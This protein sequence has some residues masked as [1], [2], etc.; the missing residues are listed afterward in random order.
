MPV[1]FL[2]IGI[3]ILKA[4]IPVGYVAMVLERELGLRAAPFATIFTL[5]IIL[6]T[7]PADLTSDILNT[8]LQK[9]LFST[10]SARVVLTSKP[11]YALYSLSVLQFALFVIAAFVN[12]FRFM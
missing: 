1:L 7:Q 11:A 8:D 3:V 12:N 6:G 2:A 10:S 5:R 9:L 4:V